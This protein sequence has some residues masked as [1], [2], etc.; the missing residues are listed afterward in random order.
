MVCLSLNPRTARLPRL[1]LKVRDNP[2][3]LHGTNIRA[4]RFPPLIFLA[5]DV[6]SPGRRVYAATEDLFRPGKVPGGTRRRSDFQKKNRAAA[7]TRGHNRKPG[8]IRADT[9]RRIRESAFQQSSRFSNTDVRRSLRIQSNLSTH[10]ETDRKCLFLLRCWGTAPGQS[11]V[12][13]LKPS[14]SQ[15][16]G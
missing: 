3:T 11:R 8:R 12:L 14:Q 4:S 7:L 6:F 2:V 9:E 15:K 5:H 13:R 10:S 16:I 1:L